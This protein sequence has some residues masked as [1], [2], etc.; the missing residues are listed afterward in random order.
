M[1]YWV[2]GRMVADPLQA[3]LLQL[4]G[5]ATGRPAAA[6]VLLSAEDPEGRGRGLETLG[7]FLASLPPLDAM[8]DQADGSVPR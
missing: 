4:W 6:A 2:G 8:L 7:G 5:L 3:K 1:W